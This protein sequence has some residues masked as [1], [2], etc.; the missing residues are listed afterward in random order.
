MSYKNL[1]DTKSFCSMACPQDMSAD[2]D[3]GPESD[4]DDDDDDPLLTEPDSDSEDLHDDDGEWQAPGQHGSIK[5]RGSGRRG[6]GRGSGR[7]NGRGRG[8]G[9]GRVAPSGGGNP[10]RRS[11]IGLADRAHEEEEDEAVAVYDILVGVGAAEAQRY[12]RR[13]AWRRNRIVKS[14]ATALD[15][16]NYE[17]VQASNAGVNTRYGTRTLCN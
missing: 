11:R 12:I 17:P 16:A 10:C 1:N 3:A 4:F 9:G 15:L 2:F 6:N 14:L 7:G 13:S 8:R 5:V